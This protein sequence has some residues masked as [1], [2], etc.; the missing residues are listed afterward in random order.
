MV[1]F[2]NKI[3]VSKCGSNQMNYTNVVKL[4]IYK[5]IMCQ[6]NSNQSGWLWIIQNIYQTVDV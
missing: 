5:Y 4:Y 2:E 3:I 6:I 1:E